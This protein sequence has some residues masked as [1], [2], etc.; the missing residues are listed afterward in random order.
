MRSND[1]SIVQSVQLVG[2]IANFVSD[3]SSTQPDDGDVDSASDTN[4][5]NDNLEMAEM[6]TVD[7]HGLPAHSEEIN[8]GYVEPHI[9]DA[10]DLNEIREI[11]TKN[12]TTHEETCLMGGGRRTSVSKS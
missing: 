5:R 11:A 9:V 1:R 7:E 10:E 4:G 6:P 8:G 2:N 3:T 12:H